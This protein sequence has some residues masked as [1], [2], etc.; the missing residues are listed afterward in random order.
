MTI[1][2][3]IQI[4]ADDRGD[5]IR[6]IRDAAQRVKQGRNEGE[7][8]HCMGA[9][10]ISLTD[11][12]CTEYLKAALGAANK[13]ADG[14]AKLATHLQSE[15]DHLRRAIGDME[16]TS[17]ELQRR[18]VAAEQEVI[19]LREALHQSYR[20]IRDGVGAAALSLI[21]ATVGAPL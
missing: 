16:A 15:L 6:L 11:D 7:W 2:I 4:A 8:Q 17:A 3:T 1:H 19:R 5:A 21:D 13:H 20:Y 12:R 18:A 14:L 10:R 9:Y